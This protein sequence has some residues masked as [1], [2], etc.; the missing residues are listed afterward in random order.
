[1]LANRLVVE[2]ASS[3][4]GA[5]GRGAGRAALAIISPSARCW[6][7]RAAEPGLDH[8]Q[9]AGGTAP[10]CTRRTRPMRSSTDRSRRNGLGRDVELVGDGC[11]GEPAVLGDELGHGLLAL[12]GVHCEGPSICVS[13]VL[14]PNVLTCQGSAAFALVSMVTE[15][16]PPGDTARTLRAAL[17]WSPASPTR[18][19]SSSTPR[20]PRTR[21]LPSTPAVT[22]TPRRRSRRTT[23]VVEGSPTASPAR[24]GVSGDAAQVLTASA[25]LSPATGPAGR[26]ANAA[27]VRRGPAGGRAR[28]CRPV[29]HGLHRDGRPD[30]RAGHRPARH[31]AIY[32]ARLVG[33]PRA[34]VGTPEGTLRARRRISHPP[35]PPVWTPSSCVPGHRRAQPD[36]PPRHHRPAALIPA[37][38][39]SPGR[40]GDASPPRALLPDSSA[41]R[42][43]SRPTRSRRRRGQPGGRGSLE[44]RA[45]PGHLDRAGL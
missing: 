4:D 10:P 8:G 35:T 5:A 3:R 18:P 26:C 40:D 14:R 27:A 39:A 30:G 23:P 32:R 45:A 43:R 9:G 17:P 44:Q 6:P 11:D 25:G 1:M 36:Q 13:V 33:A 21:S 7:G 29:R 2:P 22:P 28:G 16:T 41:A 20:C 19:R 24:P 31:R 38:S 34:G 37:W 12:F 42:G 15:I